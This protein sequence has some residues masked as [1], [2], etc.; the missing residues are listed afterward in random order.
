[1]GDTLYSKQARDGRT[2]EIVEGTDILG[3]THYSVVDDGHYTGSYNS[4][5]AAKSEY[6]NR[7]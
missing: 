1:M 3:G 7:G 2:I 6:D 4:L 5:E